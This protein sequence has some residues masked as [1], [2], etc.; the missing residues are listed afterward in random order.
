MKRPYIDTIFGPVEIGASEAADRLLNLFMDE[1]EDTYLSAYYAR[2]KYDEEDDTFYCWVEEMN[3][4]SRED[5]LQR[6]ERDRGGEWSCDVNIG[7]APGTLCVAAFY[8]PPDRTELTLAV[9]IDPLVTQFVEE[10][11]G[12]RV[13]FVLFLIRV[14]MTI[15]TDWFLTALEIEHWKRLPV[16]GIMDR[17]QLPPGTY[18]VC[19]KDDALDEAALLRG[20][21][22]HEEDVYRSILGYKFVMFFPET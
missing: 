3:L 5:L 7:F 11:E 14:A 22:V 15:G 6:L 9:T 13:P 20:L 17:Q 18:V 1:F 2:M 16:T 12:A 8:D 21:S 4:G 10:E 19:W